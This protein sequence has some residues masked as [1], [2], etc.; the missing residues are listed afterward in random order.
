[1]KENEKYVNNDKSEKKRKK[2]I[3]KKWENK[4]K[5]D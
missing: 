2:I 5:L 4:E 1:M 3:T